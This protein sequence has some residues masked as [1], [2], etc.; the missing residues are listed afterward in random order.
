[1]YATVKRRT[2]KVHIIDLIRNTIIVNRTLE[3]EAVYLLSGTYL[4]IS[5]CND[6][7]GWVGMGVS[8]MSPSLGEANPVLVGEIRLR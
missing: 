5:K 3:F 6:T 4:E 7:F 2:I 1:M 8:Q